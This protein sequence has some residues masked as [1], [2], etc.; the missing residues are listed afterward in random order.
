MSSFDLRKLLILNESE[1]DDENSSKR[2]I[3]RNIGD[4]V[5]DYLRQNECLQ[6]LLAFL[7]AEQ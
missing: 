3:C 1:D 6:Y 7:L 4:A 2:N 5:K